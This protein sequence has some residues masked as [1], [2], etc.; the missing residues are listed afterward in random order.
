[1]CIY[2]KVDI[3]DRWQETPTSIYFRVILIDLGNNQE[4]GEKKE[5]E[6]KGWDQGIRGYIELFER[7]RICNWSENLLRQIIQLRNKRRNSGAEVSTAGE[8]L[9]HW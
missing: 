4:D 2:D 1:M 3:V 9:D 7:G 5:R 6:S 8:G